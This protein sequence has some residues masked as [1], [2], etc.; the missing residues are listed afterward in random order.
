MSNNKRSCGTCTV[1]CEG[2]LV[3]NVDNVKTYPGHPC[4]YV[5][6][7]KGCGIY[8]TRPHNPCRDFFCSWVADNDDVIPDWMEPKRSKAIIMQDKLPW[9]NRKLDLVVPAAPAIPQKS[10]EWL[11]NYA[12]TNNRPFVYA[13]HHTKNGELT[14]NRDIKV[15]APQ[16][17]R[18][19]ILSWLDE[20]NKFW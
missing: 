14:G 10:M 17:L 9:K 16:P 19:N 2:W 15:F 4:E 18:D 20:G 11:V 5:I 8:E 7:C 13:E 3:I 12:K 1:C 6:S